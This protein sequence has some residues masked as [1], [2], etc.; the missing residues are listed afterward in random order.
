MASLIFIS[1]ETTNKTIAQGFALL[2]YPLV[3][4]KITVYFVTIITI[5]HGNLMYL[6][7]HLESKLKFTAKYSKVIMIT[8]A[9][10]VGKSTLL[11]HC[12]PDI[13]HITFDPHQDIYNVRQDPDLFL[14]QYKPPLILDEI[15]FYPELMSAIKRF[16]DQ[17]DQLGQYFLTGSQNLSVLKNAAESM[18]GRVSILSLHSMTLHEL[19]QQTSSHWLPFL[20]EEPD[21]LPGRFR[22]VLPDF[23]LWKSLWRGGMPGLID[24][25]DEFLGTYFSSYVQTYI[26]RDIRLVEDIRDLAGFGKFMR[27]LSAL[28]AQEMNLNEL[29]GR[30]GVTHKTV[31]RWLR[32]LEN[33]FQ[34]RL[35]QPYYGNTLKRI[36][37]KPKSNVADT[38]LAAHLIQLA[39]PTTLGSYPSLGSLFE[40]FIV[41]Q[42]YGFMSQL[43]S[44]PGIYHWRTHHGAEVDMIFE[45]N[46]YLYPVEVKMKSYL[47]KNDTRG[48]RAFRETYPS[49][50]I[51]TGVILYPGDRCFY[52]DESVIAVPCHGVFL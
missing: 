16:V 7:R 38:G 33:T 13:P 12:F 29:G 28:T 8:G 45:Q 20:L 50:N 1:D 37:K 14:K 26:E 15:Q 17:S 18:A 52:L 39:S 44:K 35:I 51:K 21:Q 22:G 31:D 40:S 48:L 23:G 2:L 4:G 3:D 19:H 32:L 10:Q 43:N 24:Q 11:K 5:I 46:G 36:T 47:N 9:R 49:Q 41:N 30:I 42:V 27:V 34:W 6:T 25:P